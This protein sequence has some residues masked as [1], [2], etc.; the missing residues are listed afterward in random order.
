MNCYPSSKLYFMMSSIM[1]SI[2][3]FRVKMH[4][5]IMRLHSRSLLRISQGSCLGKDGVGAFPLRE[6][7]PKKIFD[8]R[9]LNVFSKPLGSLINI[10]VSGSFAEPLQCLVWLGTWS[11]QQV[12]NNSKELYKFCFFVMAHLENVILILKVQRGYNHTYTPLLFGR[13]P[14]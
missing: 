5:H 9:R 4:F 13:L 6:K 10:L 3:T 2:G 7:I 1:Y 14:I 12:H 11:K 8:C